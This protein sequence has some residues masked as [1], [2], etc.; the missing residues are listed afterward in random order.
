MNF[1]G[2]W[3]RDSSPVLRDISIR[4]ECGKLYGISGKVGSGKS[5]LFMAILGE[6]PY[7][8]G[9]VVKSGTVAFVEQEPVI[10]TGTFKD[11]LLFAQAFEPEKYDRTLRCC[12]LEEDLGLWKAGDQTEIGERGVT[13]SG[14][15][16]ARLALA[17]ALYAEA[18]IYLLDD[19]FSA[20]DARVGRSLFEG[21]LKEVVGRKTVVLAT[22]QTHFLS[23]C[24]QV[25][26]M[27]NGSILSTHRPSGQLIME[28]Q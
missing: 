13:L 24:D 20:V 8:E 25:T 21:L 27:E 11:N 6:V 26:T 4:F 23:K 3:K 2:Y 7:C 14:G 5:S 9:Q 22:H 10:F 16:K 17:R 15:Q 1:N 12:C 28:G 19:P 18:D